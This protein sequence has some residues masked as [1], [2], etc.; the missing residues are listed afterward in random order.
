MYEN[1]S[2]NDNSQRNINDTFSNLSVNREEC[3][4]LDE[5]CFVEEEQNGH[6]GILVANDL[7]TD[8]P[9]EGSN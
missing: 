5:T 9:Q 7:A 6:A 4:V 1:L 3:D 2:D 8:V